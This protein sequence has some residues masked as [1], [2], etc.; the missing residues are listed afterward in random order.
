MGFIVLETAAATVTR[1]I[2]SWFSWF[3]RTM[4]GGRR[5]SALLDHDAFPEK[6]KEGAVLF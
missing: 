1:I 6:R 2:I 5:F 4:E 3:C